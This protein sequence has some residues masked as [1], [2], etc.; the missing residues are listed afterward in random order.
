MAQR[1]RGMSLSF[2]LLLLTIVFVMIGEVLIV[3]PSVV[4]YHADWLTQRVRQGQIAGMSALEND[5]GQWRG[6]S[7]QRMLATTGNL[8]VRLRMTDGAQALLG[9]FDR[10]E[11]MPAIDLRDIEP[12]AFF[13][14]TLLALLDD[15]G[16]PMLVIGPGQTE[17]IAEVQVVVDRGR[18]YADLT[19]QASRTVAI[20]FAIALL[21]GGIMFFAL[22]SMMVRPIR[23]MTAAMVAF[24]NEPDQLRPTIA[25]SDRGDEIGLAE[26]ELALMQAEIRNA[27]IQRERL[28]ALGAAMT[29]VNHDLRN[30]LTSAQVFSD[31][32]MGSADP[33]VRKVAPTLVAAIDRAVALTNQT[34]DFAKGTPPRPRPVQFELA[35]LI[36]DVA[37][38]LGLEQNE[39]V[40]FSNQV[41]TY[42]EVE[43]DPDHLFRIFQNLMRNALEALEAGKRPSPH[44][45]V[46]AREEPAALIIDVTDNGPGMPQ[47][48]LKHIYQPFR[49][50]ARSGGTG[51]G[52][53]NARELMRAHGGDLDLAATGGGGTTFRLTL[54]Q[55]LPRP[56]DRPRPDDA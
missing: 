17:T 23:R 33:K 6:A 21:V 53:V 1:R 35:P 20:S 15:E 29:K 56:D 37:R 38:S 19:Q 28:A 18:L 27:L 44:L 9:P 13:R 52:L 55:P 2:R 7:D 10:W 11:R 34:L 22:D 40:T 41:P 14:L 49:G 50:S 42:I 25:P 31:Q 4:Q 30:M 45:S 51:L 46:A 12:A 48:A 39:R 54:P 24:R 16:G 26:M 47:A 32:M 43:A 3:A 5:R 8:A 36:D